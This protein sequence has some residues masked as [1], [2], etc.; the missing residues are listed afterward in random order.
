[1][2][3]PAKHALLNIDIRNKLRLGG[4]FEVFSDSSNV[5]V[6]STY[7]NWRL[8]RVIHTNEGEG[9]DFKE[10]KLRHLR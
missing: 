6:R 4:N 8:W 2:M 9:F 10:I 1:M 3:S 7:K 5:W